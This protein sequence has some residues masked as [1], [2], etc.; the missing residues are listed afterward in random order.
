MEGNIA[1]VKYDNYT[2]QEDVTK[3]MEKCPVDI[4]CYCG[5][6]P[7]KQTVPQQEKPTGAQEGEA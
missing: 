4:I 6:E 5:K 1:S 7:V 2:G 3:A